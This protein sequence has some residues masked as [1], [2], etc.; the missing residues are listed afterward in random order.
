MKG[1]GVELSVLD[2]QEMR[3]LKK[4]PRRQ[5]E[6]ERERKL[7]ETVAAVEGEE[8]EEAAAQKKLS[9]DINSCPLV[10]QCPVQTVVVTAGCSWAGARPVWGL[11]ELTTEPQRPAPK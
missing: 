10:G 6:K 9:V 7:F 11:N 4:R 8:T 2:K 1:G 5:R 3:H